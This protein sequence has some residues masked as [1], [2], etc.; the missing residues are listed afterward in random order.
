M[1]DLVLCADE[2]KAAMREWE[3][4]S[5]RSEAR[6]GRGFF[7]FADAK[8]RFESR[9][10]GES[11]ADFAERQRE[12]NFHFWDYKLQK[13][14]SKLAPIALRLTFGFAGPGSAE[15]ANKAVARACTRKRATVRRPR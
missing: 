10:D 14:N 11:S 2:F 12:E 7:K 4:Y 6:M 3:D 8:E 9:K 1:Y 15:R 13:E 5:L